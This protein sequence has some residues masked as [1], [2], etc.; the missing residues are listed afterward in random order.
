MTLHAGYVP[1]YGNE[2]LSQSSF[3]GGDGYRLFKN[4]TIAWESLRHIFLAELASVKNQAL[5]TLFTK[6]KILP[7]TF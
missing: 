3:Q 7:A 2:G 1:G 5:M 4:Q 6:I